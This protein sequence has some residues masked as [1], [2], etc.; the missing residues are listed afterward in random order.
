M[1]WQPTPVFL[2]GK[3]HGQRSL[4]GKES[5]MTE[6]LT[7]LCFIVIHHGPEFFPKL[8]EAYRQHPEDLH[9]LKQRRASHT[10][11]T[12]HTNLSSAIRSSLPSKKMT[13]SLQWAQVGTFVWWCMK[14]RY[15]LSMK[16]LGKTERSK[17]EE[18]QWQCNISFSI[19]NSSPRT[20]NTGLSKRMINQH[21]C[22]AYLGTGHQGKVIIG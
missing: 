8:I 18:S 13:K 6:W 16:Y 9:G 20:L 2:P 14:R 21:T 12:G 15:R 22:E 3:P 5:D 1:K 11:S 7:L 10:D 17:Q 4:A 19:V